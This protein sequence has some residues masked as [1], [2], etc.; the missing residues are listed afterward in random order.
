MTRTDPTP[1]RRR[2]RR[3]ALLAVVTAVPLAVAG[4]VAG[5]IGGA[6]ERLDAIP[7]IVVN[8][9][10]MVTMTTPDGEEQP[11]LAGRQLV[12][13]LT[14]D[15]QTGFDWTISNDEEAADALA[16][17]DAYAVL[18]IPPDFSESVTSLSGDA[19]TT[20]SLDIRTD[21]AHGYLAGVVGSAVGDAVATAFGNELTTQYLEGLYGNL[22]TVGGSLGDA[23]DGAG[24]LADGAD[25]L[26]TG[27]DQ[28]ASGLGSAAAGTSQA[29]D[30]ASA[31][32]S[33]IDQYTAGVEQLAGGVATLDQQAAALDGIT[34]G[35]AQYVGGVEAA[36]T[37]IDGGIAKY[38]GGVRAAGSGVDSGIGSYVD[39][40]D[41]AGDGITAGTGEYV[42]NVAALADAADDLA[43]SIPALIQADPTGAAAQAA[44]EAYAAQAHA[45]ADG[46]DTL[47][48]ET[49]GAF[50]QLV[51]GGD[52]LQA[53]TADAFSQLGAG[54]DALR[55][56][57]ADA[58][59]Q[60]V[61]GGRQ[62]VAG[63][64]SGV[65]GLQSG[66]S[67]L[68]DGANQAAA[69]SPQ[70]RDGATGI[71]TGVSGIA[72]G[73]T[74][75]EAGA[76]AS[77]D[78]A[79][80][81]AGGT[82]ELADGL[83]EG[84]EGT[85]SLSDL[86]PEETA[87]VVADPVVAEATRD[88]EIDSVGQVVAMLLGPIGLWLGA[89]A[90]FLVF[91]PFT[92]EALAS[93]APTGRLVARTLF[94]GSLVGLVQAAAVVVLMHTALG[95]DW[96]LLPQTLACSALLAVAFTAVHAFLSAWLGRAGT[97]VS[98]VLVV[99]QLAASGGLYPLEIVS[100]PYQ[101]I[102]PFLPLTW[103]VQGM[104][105]IVS[106]AGGPAVWAAAGVTALFAVLGAVGT[107]FVVGR[108]RA[109][110]PAA[111]LAAQPA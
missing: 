9:D 93:T 35:V 39:G 58:F 77:A 92:R 22:V 19:P 4:L 88:H 50:T 80:E 105:H 8:N 34:S 72:N 56:G 10:E 6:D 5:A 110:R 30:G 74:R 101:A 62:L 68:S 78:G 41:T 104:Q 79:S 65:D 36:G 99:L 48:A 102:S 95:V 23:A 75:L 14:G 13:E 43:A 11:V 96:A 55:A 40:I 63:T 42:G 67:Q 2:G 61:A 21:D 57:T 20:A 29:A 24:Q 52:A 12:T 7:A 47:V 106:G 71:A 28:L 97:I 44:I 51:E 27:L 17:G 81:L 100:G 3:A 46:G 87:G 60:L 49:G 33:G 32:A 64:G 90:L 70:I 103:A 108:R 59:A 45:L 1:A 109:I 73:L 89:M 69:G 91:R 37:G 54:G 84:A 82:Q 26:S 18:T 83:A 111:R 76:S 94:R 85:S 66:I 86:D 38:V 16:A 15:G 107:A 53:G 31:Y 98:L 25:S